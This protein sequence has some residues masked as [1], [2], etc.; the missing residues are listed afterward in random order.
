[1]IQRELILHER[2]HELFLYFSA[3]YTSPGLTVLFLKIAHVG[4][5]RCAKYILQ[6]KHMDLYIENNFSS[7]KSS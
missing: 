5:I 7:L 2:L 6:T 1:M 4:L 3:K